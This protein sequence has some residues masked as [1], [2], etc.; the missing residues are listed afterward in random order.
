MTVLKYIAQNRI[1]GLLPIRRAADGRMIHPEILTN[2]VVELELDKADP[3][4]VCGALKPQNEIAYREV[5]GRPFNPRAEEFERT[6]AVNGVIRTN[7]VA[8]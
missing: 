6:P 8:G 2:Q 4:V 3:L 5:G 1:V 7:P